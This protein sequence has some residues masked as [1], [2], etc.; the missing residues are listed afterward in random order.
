MSSAPTP[1][2]EPARK[3]AGWLSLL[4]ILAVVWGGSQL[5]S[6]WREQRNIEQVQAH[7]RPGD[8]LMYTTDTCPYCAAARRWLQSAQVPWRECNIDR[9]AACL[10]TFQAKGAPGVP[11][12][13]VRGQWRLGFDAHWLGLALQTRQATATP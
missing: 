3:R 5:W 6:T 8:I 12:M 9:D 10:A 2:S 7:A 4:L 11:L 13:Q 1:P